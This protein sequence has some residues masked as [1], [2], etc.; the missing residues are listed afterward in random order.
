MRLSTPYMLQYESKMIKS[1]IINS[2]PGE[3]NAG[4][5]GF[6]YYG[7]QGHCLYG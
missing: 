3:G 1:K 5:A 2:I 7:S 6:D 4:G